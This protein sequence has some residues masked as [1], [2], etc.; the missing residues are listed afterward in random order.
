LTIESADPV[1]APPVPALVQQPVQIVQPAVIP[2][3]Q[4]VVVVP[5]VQ[6]AVVVPVQTPSPIQRIKFRLSARGLEDR[7]ILGTSDPYVKVYSKEGSGAEVLL[8]NTNKFQDQENADWPYVFE[9]DYNP[10]ITQKLHFLVLDDDENRTDE[11]LGN[12]WTDL[13]D[14][15]KQGQAQT[16]SLKKGTLTISKA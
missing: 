14:Y 4:P 16:L 2:V 7:D 6:P 8:G 1:V 3:A 10:S 12:V 15:V 11:E 9:I 13:N 5:A